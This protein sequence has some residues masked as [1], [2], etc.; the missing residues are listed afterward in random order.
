MKRNELTIMK[1]LLNSDIS[2]ESH[3]FTI[4]F[5]INTLWWSLVIFG[6]NPMILGIKVTLEYTYVI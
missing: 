6:G 5:M 4:H 3:C 2:D 1:Y